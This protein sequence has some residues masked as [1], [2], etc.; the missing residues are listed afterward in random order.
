MKKT[1]ENSLATR[2]NSTD[3]DAQIDPNGKVFGA[4]ARGS[5]TT[6]AI[7]VTAVSGVTGVGDL[8][9][10]LGSLTRVR[11]FQTFFRGGAA[12]CGRPVLTN[13][14]VSEEENVLH[15]V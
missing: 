4:V 9:W 13:G 12:Q 14:K 15:D 1:R 6:R 7:A 3:N 8:G 10:F 2:R 11:P 5:R